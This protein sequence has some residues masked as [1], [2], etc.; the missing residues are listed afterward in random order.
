MFQFSLTEMQTRVPGELLSRVG[1]YTEFAPSIAAPIGLALTGPLVDSV[2]ATEVC[3]AVG[4]LSLVACA[5]PLSF[6]SLRNL[7]RSTP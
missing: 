5:V 1:S 7:E 3:V 4:V 2:G 6:R